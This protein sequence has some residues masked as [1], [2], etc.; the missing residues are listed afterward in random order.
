LDD[1]YVDKEGV[2][3]FRISKRKDEREEW[4]ILFHAFVEAMLARFEGV[5]W[6]SI[7]KFDILLDKVDPDAQPG[8]HPDAPYRHQHCIAEILERLLCEEL[9]IRWDDYLK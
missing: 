3:Q 1:F 8:D 6:E 9:G 2:I 5:S 7:D 4:L